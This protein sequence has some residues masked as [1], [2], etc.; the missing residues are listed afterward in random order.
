MRPA[1][2]R[3]YP[4]AVH[5]SVERSGSTLAIVGPL[6]MLLGKAK[7]KWEPLCRYANRRLVSLQSR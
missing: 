6:G 4:L 5:C 3:D 1:S 7:A 2:D